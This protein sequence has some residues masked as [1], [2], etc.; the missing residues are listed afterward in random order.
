MTYKELDPADQLKLAKAMMVDTA[1]DWLEQLPATD[2][3]TIQ[4]LQTAFEK[5]YVKPAALRF[6]SACEVFQKKQEAGESVDA[7]WDRMLFYV[8]V[9]CLSKNLKSLT[10]FL[11]VIPTT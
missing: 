10:L 5:R 9:S 11:D 7:Y 6:R 8:F 4:A 3:A 1:A 2:T